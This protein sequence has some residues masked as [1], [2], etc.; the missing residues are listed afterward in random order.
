VKSI[1]LPL[2]APLP[3]RF[4]VEH[5]IKVCIVALLL[6]AV[7]ITFLPSLVKDISSD[8]YLSPDNT[9]LVYRSRAK[10]LFGLSDPFVVAIQSSGEQGIYTAEGLTLL[11]RI[12]EQL[13]DLTNIDS[14]RVSSLASEN[15]IV[16]EDESIDISPFFET[17]VLSL[18]EA[19]K[20]R[21][22]VQNFPIL[23]GNLV[24]ID[25]KVAIIVADML[26]E[27]LAEDT[28]LEIERLLNAQQ[29]PS[30]IRV[31]LAG[32]G[33]VSAYLGKYMDD[34]AKRLNPIAGLVIMGIILLA[35]RRVSPVLLSLCIIMA[36]LLLT[37]SLMSAFGVRFFIITNALP[38]ILIGIA[39][40]DS[41]HVFT[42]YFDIL[43]SNPAAQKKAA[44]TQTMSDL[45]LPISLTSV[46][47]VAGFIGIYLTA[48]MPPFKYF[49]LYAAIGVVAAWAY[50]LLFLPA[51]LALIQPQA[52][53]AAIRRYRAGVADPLG[54]ALISL[55]MFTFRFPLGVIA[56][57]SLVA[58]VG[59]YSTM[60]LEVDEDRIGIF[61]PDEPIHQADTAI[62]EHT[63]GSGMLD[64]VI[65]ST[66][67]E[68][69]MQLEALAKIEALQLFVETLPG[70]T[71]SVSIVDYI[72]QMNKSFNG[73]AEVFYALPDSPDAVAQYL[74]VYGA[75][76]SPE[77]LETMIDYD[78]QNALVRVTMNKTTY[79]DI[80]KVV[81]PLQDYIDTH[82]N[83]QRLQATLS[84]RATLTYHWVKDLAESHIAGTVTALLLVLLV[85]SLIFRS[86]IAGLFTLTPVLFSL[87]LVYTTMVVYQLDLGVGSSMFAA[88]SV[89]LGIDFSI[90]TIERF[91]VLYKRHNG[92]FEAVIRA[93]Y[94]LAG[95]A[96][97][98][99][100]LAI[101]CGFGVLLFSTIGSLAAFGGIV[102]LSVSCSFL[103]SM[104]LLPAMIFVV[105]PKFICATE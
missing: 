77:D 21:E 89:G 91:K 99:N 63:N 73:G 95:R 103:A 52:S 94:G 50:S 104:M 12:T 101:S 14:E 34:D 43:I 26:D 59:V 81:K 47:T 37:F 15:N 33:A 48:Y 61:H 18:R 72:K 54:A 2:S 41:I 29:Y 70:V 39:V 10:D 87:L 7:S 102:V 45:W 105:E 30:D 38:V 36:T 62:N 83:E 76:A 58:V 35:F 16:A 55:G 84:G 9:A 74:L 19:E 75:I 80:L 4:C 65:E 8:A 71:A 82:F 17:E 78:Y 60:Q 96:L 44:I 66:D 64:V 97:F 32:E 5:P 69:L 79:K 100:F 24:S 40:A 68:G 90:H 31:H 25:G 56:S 85:A 22:G 46:T 88:V 3:F 98:F 49:G 20:V 13:Q 27:S 23:L 53:E 6:I 51:A 93:F 67:A 28:Y 57:A 92:K 42:H 11:A 1:D 86:F